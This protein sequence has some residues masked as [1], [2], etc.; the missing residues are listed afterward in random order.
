MFVVK[1][2]DRFATNV[3]PQ[4]NAVSA[5]GSCDDFDAI[6]DRLIVLTVRVIVLWSFISILTTTSFPVLQGSK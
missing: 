3:I 5:N 4:V 6:W 1:D 2:P